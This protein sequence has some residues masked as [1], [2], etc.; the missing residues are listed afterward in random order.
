MRRAAVTPLRIVFA[1]QQVPSAAA[2]GFS[3]P[4]TLVGAVQSD[5]A[6]IAVTCGA[7]AA[8]LAL[9]LTGFGQPD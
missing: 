8:F 2:A 1:A 7:A 9:A 5:G 4:L 3:S 6:C